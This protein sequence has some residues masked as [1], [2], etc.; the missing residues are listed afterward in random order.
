MVGESNM[1]KVGFYIDTVLKDGEYQVKFSHIDKIRREIGRFYWAFFFVVVDNDG[2]PRMDYELDDHMFC[3][4]TTNYYD[5]GIAPRAN[6]QYIKIFKKIARYNG[7]ND[8][9]LLYWH[10]NN[11]DVEDFSNGGES[12]IINVKVKYQTKG[13]EGQDIKPISKV[14]HIWN[15]LREEWESTLGKSRHYD[16][17]PIITSMTTAQDLVD[18][19]IIFK[20]SVPEIM[21]LCLEG[22][23]THDKMEKLIKQKKEISYDL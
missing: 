18:E 6:H 17:K 22:K 21:E 12:P 23:I 9:D 20:K 8:K 2:I 10:P 11:Q 16:R 13:L 5:L 7:Y 3:G 1:S 19:E 4:L 15:P 14:S